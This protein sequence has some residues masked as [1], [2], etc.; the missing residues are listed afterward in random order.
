VLGAG[1]AAP[2]RDVEQLLWTA[3]A[4]ARM[5]ALV[6]EDRDA[7]GALMDRA[8]WDGL[9]GCLTFP[10]LMDE[11]AHEINRSARGG[12]PLSCCFIDL[13]G[14][15][16]I[17]DIHGHLRGNEVLANVGLIL[18]N[19]VRSCDSVGRYGGDE[20]VAVLPQT[21]QDDATVLAARLCSL[22]TGRNA[23]RFGQPLTASI[24]VAEWTREMGR[25][26]LLM[27]A[28]NALYA[29]KTTPGSVVASDRPLD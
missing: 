27:A 20:F 6:V 4:Y 14:F 23:N 17:N 3:D 29:A 10:S 18:R 9:T 28:D 15:K 11:L 12:Q 22:I 21:D 5:I 13:D 2:P 1:F 26:Q 8:R 24:G 25:E 19:G 16:Q 7:L